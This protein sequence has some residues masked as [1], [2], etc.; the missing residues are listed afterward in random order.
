MKK[1]ISIIIL[2]YTLNGFSQKEANIWYFGEN[3][4]LDFNSG[5]PQPLTGGQLNTFEGCSTFSDNSGNLLFYSDGTTVWKD[6]KSVV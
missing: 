5:T 2:L 3:A 4:G 6:R 1:I